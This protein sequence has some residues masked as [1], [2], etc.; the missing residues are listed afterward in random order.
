M[1]GERGREGEMKEGDGGGEGDGKGWERR[2]RRERGFQPLLQLSGYGADFCTFLAIFASGWVI[3]SLC[4]CNFSGSTE[5]GSLNSKL[6]RP[7]RTAFG[8]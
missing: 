6:G 3:R 8:I 2:E 1:R 5:D 7:T 4:S